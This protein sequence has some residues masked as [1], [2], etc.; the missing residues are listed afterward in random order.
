M[1]LYDAAAS[2][3]TSEERLDFMW[4]LFWHLDF[5]NST[6]THFLDDL[7]CEMPVLF[8]DRLRNYVD[9]ETRFKRNKTRLFIASKSLIY[10]FEQSDT[11]CKAQIK[12]SINGTGRFINN[13][14]IKWLCSPFKYKPNAQHAPELAWG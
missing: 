3:M 2:N 5:G 7:Y 9:I 13:I 6:P 10:F 11:S 8:G 1:K 12:I 4:V 14:I